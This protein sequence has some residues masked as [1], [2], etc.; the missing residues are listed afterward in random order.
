MEC[1]R[2]QTAGDDLAEL[3]WFDIKNFN[4]SESTRRLETCFGGIPVADGGEKR[5]NSEFVDDPKHDAANVT[6]YVDAGEI[7]GIV[8]AVNDCDYDYF[9]TD[10]NVRG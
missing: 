7:I 9:L 1:Q 10:R 6:A 8:I 5:S 4:K 2:R 3:D